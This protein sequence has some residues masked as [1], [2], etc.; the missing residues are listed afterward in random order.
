MSKS[1]FNN[2]RAIQIAIAL[3][4]LAFVVLRCTESEAAETT[5]E[6]GAAIASDDLSGIALGFSERF[7]GKWEVGAMLY[8][9]QDFRK[10]EGDLTIGNNAIFY[11]GRVVN[12][13][14]RLE[15]SLGLAYWQNTNRLGGCHTTFALGVGLRLSTHAWLSA[16]HFSNAGTCTPN[17][18]QD[19]L[20]FA[21]R[22][23]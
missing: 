21:W 1:P 2:P 10:P 7:Y 14:R 20:T 12:W 5:I 9:E 13:Q 22:F 8:G 6:L 15:L 16:R 4:L 19:S 18:G 11:A 23:Q 3:F 17:S